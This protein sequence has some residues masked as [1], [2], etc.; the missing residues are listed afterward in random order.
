LQASESLKEPEGMFLPQGIVSFRLGAFFSSAFGSKGDRSARRK[1]TL[2]NGRDREKPLKGM[3]QGLFVSNKASRKQDRIKTGNQ[4]V[5]YP[6]F[7]FAGKPT[8]LEPVRF[9]SYRLE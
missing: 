7:F 1:R 2:G 3:M 6:V 9:P 8:A 5:F 4:P